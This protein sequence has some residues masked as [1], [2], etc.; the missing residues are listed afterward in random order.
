[1]NGIPNINNFGAAKRL[2][3]K[4]KSRGLRGSERGG[5]NLASSQISF[6]VKFVCEV[7][8]AVIAFLVDLR[9]LSLGS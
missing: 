8:R 6:T 2:N 5:S 7:S 1:M 3:K 4:Q 9:S